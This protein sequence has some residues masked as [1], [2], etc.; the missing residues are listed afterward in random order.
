VPFP[1]F[2]RGELAQYIENQKARHAKY[3]FETNRQDRFTPD[4][5]EKLKRLCAGS[6][7]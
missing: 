2:F 4:G 7:D 1:A 3:L 5:F 6:G